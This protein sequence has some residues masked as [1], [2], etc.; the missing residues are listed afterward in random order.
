MAR[1][2][3][4]NLYQDLSRARLGHGHFAEFCR[5]LQLN[6]LECSHRFL[7]SLIL[8]SVEVD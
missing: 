4:A 7:K 5:L 3:A 1:A 2:C 6:E 8:D